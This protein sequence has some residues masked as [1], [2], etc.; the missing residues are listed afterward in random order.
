VILTGPEIARLHRLGEITLEPFREDLVNPCSYN[1]RLGP[2]LRTHAG[3]VIDTRGENPLAE[4]VIPST[5]LV[6]RPGL[7]YLGTTVER[8]GASAAVPSLIGRSSVGRLGLF[9]QFAADLGHPGVAH[10]WTLEIEV[11]QPVR[12][13]PEMVIGQVSFWTTVGALVPYTGRFGRID[14]ATVPPPPHLTG[15]RSAL[16]IPPVEDAC[17]S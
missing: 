10:H 14:Q 12:V 17:R 8:I 9:V 7:V 6:L 15:E 1:Y 13:Y 5:G 2:V 11:V 4:T 3:D 16:A